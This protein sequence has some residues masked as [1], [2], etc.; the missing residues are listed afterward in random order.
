[1]TT[2]STVVAKMGE[3][4]NKFATESKFDWSLVQL[5]C[6][7]LN[8]TPDEIKKTQYTIRRNSQSLEWGTW[9]MPESLKNNEVIITA[10]QSRTK[11]I[12]PTVQQEP[13]HNPKL[14]IPQT[15]ENI[16]GGV[17]II[18]HDTPEIPFLDT[19]FVPYGNYKDL[20]KIIKSRIFYPTFITGHSGNGKSS[21]VLHICAKHKIPVIR[22][23]MNKM[24]DEE[25]LIGC[26]TLVNGEIVAKEGPAL[27]AMRLGCILQLEELS[28][29]LEENESV[30]IGTVDNWSPVKLK[31]LDSSI[32]YPVV[33]YN[34][35]TKQLEDD[36][37]YIIEDKEDDLYEVTLENGETIILT[38]NH[39]FIVDNNG[40]CEELTI[41]SGLTIGSNVVVV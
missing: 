17:K 8:M 14:T 9:F 3:L 11:Q 7:K 33:S 1:M 23:N 39:P 10:S 37:G 6:K 41:D 2:I 27:S 40:V 30:R 36:T 12:Q 13:M 29:C 34:M 25:K 28:A 15:T 24:T 35:E 21:Q 5:A 31:D 32:V 22:V 38:S 20:E 19:K 16:M 4:S 18:Q 26:N